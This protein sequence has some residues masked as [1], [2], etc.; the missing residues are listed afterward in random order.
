MIAGSLL[1]RARPWRTVRKLACSQAVGLRC[2][3]D[4]PAAAALSTASVGN[5]VR[6]KTP[7]GR[8]CWGALADVGSRQAHVIENIFDAPNVQG[9]TETI[10]RLLPPLPVDPCPAV[11]FIGLNYHSHAEETG[12]KAPM[13]PIFTF[14]NP[15][16]VVGPDSRVVIP[17]VAAQKPEVD[18]EGELAI[19]IGKRLKDV[20]AE[21]ATQGILGVT[22]S[23]DISARRWQGKKGGGQWSRAKSFD[24]FCPLGPSIAPMDKV[25][26]AL[27]KDG[28][29]LKLQTV[30]NGQ[31]MQ[32]GNTSDMIFTVAE[33]VSYISQGTTIL[34]GSIILT[35]TPPG[36]GYAR[37]PPVYLKAGD[38]VEVSLEGTG[39]LTNFI[40]A[41]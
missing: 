23:N 9:P 28:K 18:Y 20:S 21:E 31:M 26:D 7:G 2:V 27:K 24:T 12:Q 39:T 33:I 37:D 8:E 11:L 29:G 41:S 6:F 1:Q 38:V 13:F 5:F 34:P 32:N 14:K 10:D 17:P 36:V 15:M 3:S 25:G 19:V 40:G 35:G 30:L 16:A 4:H 22:A